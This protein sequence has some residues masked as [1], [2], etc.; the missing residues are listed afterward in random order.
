MTQYTIW[1]V[2]LPIYYS[3]QVWNQDHLVYCTIS[4]TPLN[5][6]LSQY[7]PYQVVLTASPRLIAVGN[8]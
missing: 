3:Q 1:Y 8:S 2:T 6:A 4:G 5:C 7:T